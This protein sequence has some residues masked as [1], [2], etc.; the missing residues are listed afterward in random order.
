MIH[1]GRRW[2][3]YI[4]SSRRRH[5]KYWRDWSSDVCSSDLELR[6]GSTAN[7]LFVPEGAEAGLASPVRF[8]LSGRSAYVDGQTVTLAPPVGDPGVEDAERPLAG[9]VAVVTGAAR[10]IGAAIAQVMARDGAHVVAVDVPAAG[11]N[12]AKVANEIGGQAVPP[13]NPA[14]DA[15]PRL[16]GDPRD[17]PGGGDVAVPNCGI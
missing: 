11:D 17:G 6:N 10:G 4:F 12:L 15:P 7:L 5:T 9:R 14:D 13:D 3:C 1:I 2:I 8:F 16:V